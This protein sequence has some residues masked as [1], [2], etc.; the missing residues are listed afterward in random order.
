MPIG[1]Q[2]D[3]LQ[4]NNFRGLQE[5]SIDISRQGPTVLIGA[6]NSCKSTIVDALALALGGPAFYRFEP[7]RYDYF[8]DQSG[9]A[10]K[11]FGITTRFVAPPGCELPAVRGA[12]GD[13]V[14][15][16]GACAS[17]TTDKNGRFTHQVRLI[18]DQGESIALPLHTPLKK[19]DAPAWKEHN[20][21]FRMRTAR[22]MDVSEHQ[23]EIWSLQPTNLYKSL[24]EW[25]TGPLQRLAKM[26]T[27]RFLET[28]WTFEY[29]GKKQAMPKG[30]EAV[31]NFFSAAVRDFPFWKDD[32]K[33]R[34][35]D[36][37]SKYVG[38]DTRIEL[39]PSILEVE[40][41][42]V[43]QL[44]VAF[45]TDSGGATTPLESMG[46]GWQ[47]LVRIAALDAL[48]QYPAE[49]SS[50]VVL[51]MEEPE[52]FLHAHLC[53][54]LRTV[55][56]RL[57]SGGWTIVMTTHSSSMVSFAGRQTIVR[58]TRRGQRVHSRQLQ[59]MAIA[60]GP[61][62]QERLDERGAHEMLFAQRAVLCEGIDDV[63]AVRSYIENRRRLDIDARSVSIIR[64]G[65]VGQ[66][67]NFAAVAS[68]LGIP[69]CAVS[70][71]DLEADGAV[72]QSTATVRDTLTRIQGPL[73]K[74]VEWPIDLEACLG[75]KQGKARPEWQAKEIE[76]KTPDELRADC[77]GYVATCEKII[78]WI[79]GEE[80]PTTPAA[81]AA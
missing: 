25:K 36:T 58:L 46:Q 62:F 49:V 79:D 32:L 74:Q 23:P 41:W 72:K 12:Y 57:A 38:H 80:N 47:S 37:L 9:T 11:S 54:K 66:L 50:R 51:L 15:V 71:Q 53:R 73:D 78:Q 81:G 5:L 27:A 44:A 68:A 18:D 59:T 77:G 67:G 4:V 55:L 3:S 8:H 56:D 28:K 20:V 45:A 16:H 35:Q 17:G 48:S 63:F 40:E 60:D 29:N 1:I 75:K 70:D 34:L 26:L 7:S 43:Q 76:P 33:P 21:N 10:A 2:L 31:H 61:K 14:V 64:T 42:I 65:D 6:N 19:S 13:P 52:S 69:W 22:W 30:I 39:R 24:Y